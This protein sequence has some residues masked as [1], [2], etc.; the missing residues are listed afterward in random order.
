MEGP[1]QEAFLAQRIYD[2]LV[3]LIHLLTQV[4]R[5][6]VGKLPTYMNGFATFLAVFQM[7]ALWGCST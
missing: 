1:W 3:Y 2:I 7:D 4:A 6:S 5:S